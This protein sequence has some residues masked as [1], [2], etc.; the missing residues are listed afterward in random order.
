L[1]HYNKLV[2]DRIPDII[3]AS[4]KK[5]VTAMLEHAEYLTQLEKKLI[6]E[7]DEYLA[8]KDVRGQIE[9]LADI[10]EVVYALAEAKG[11]TVEELE[12]IRTRKAEERGAFKERTLLKWVDD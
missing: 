10:L 1:P 5:C 6:E 2:R 9:E 3:K 8:S 11:V 7:C 4:G 12:S